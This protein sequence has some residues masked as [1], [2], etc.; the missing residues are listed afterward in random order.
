[1]RLQFI[2]SEIGVGLRR[3]LSMTISVILVTFVSLT[4]VGA[5]GLLQLQINEMK[6]DWYDK[7]EVSIFLCPADS[8]VPTCAGGEAT[9]EQIDALRTELEGEELSP[10][11]KEIF[12]E[13]KED[14]FASF[15][16]Q[17]ADEFWAQGVTAD[18][19]QASFRVALVDPEQ[20]Q[21]LSD[22]FT[23]RQGVEEVRD[24]R[25]VIEPLILVLNRASLVAAALAAVMLLAAV[26]LITT[27][28]RLS[29][30]SRRRETGIMRLVGASNLFIQLPFM[31]EG[32]IA[33]T[34]GA[35]LSVAGLWFGVKYLVEDWLAQSVRF[36]QYIGTDA[37]WTIAPALLVIAIGLATVSSVVTLSRYTKV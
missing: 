25:E 7:V 12:F 26:L 19:L 17:F 3:N 20:Y 30:M 22:L 36:V 13:S 37:V 15:T 21:V 18:D 16:E 24:Q 10:Y 11:V 6:D 9:A 23:G 2:L 35:A 27:T 32:A 29:A 34:I 28:I 31:L 4:F 1:M 14:A 5:A 33:A 8:E